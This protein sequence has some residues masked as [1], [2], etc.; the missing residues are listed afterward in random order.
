MI[1]YIKSVC[2]KDAII[3]KLQKENEELK[4]R[5]QELE[6]LVGMNSRN[7]SKP[8]S[9]DFGANSKPQKK[10]RKK[11]KRK[12]QGAQKGHEPHLRELLPTEAVTETI[13]LYPDQCTCGCSD[14]DP[15]DEEPLRFQTIDIPPIKPEVNEFVQHMMQCR[16]CGE[17]V[18]QPLSDDIKRN[19]FGP[20]VLAIV[21]VLTGMLN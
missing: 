1:C 16:Q 14:L 15:C 10:K 20:G 19:V 6:R 2:D 17:V 4:K 3:E 13:D 18:Y 5:I 11:G 12:K 8:P 21:G 7:S 9:S